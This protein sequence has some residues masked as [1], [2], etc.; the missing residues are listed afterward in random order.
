MQPINA[1]PLVS[2]VIPAFNGVNFLREAVESVFAQTYPNIELILVDDGST[3]DTWTVIQ[4]YGKRVRAIHKENGGVASALNVGILQARGSLI[5]WLS[6]DDLFFP[7]K[8]DRQVHFLEKHPQY[9]VC[10]TDFEI[11]NATGELLK[12]YRAPWYPS[13]E[14]PRHFLADMH[15]NGSTVLMRK[16]CYESAGGFNECL[17]H[18]QDLDMWLR[19]AEK[20]ELGHLPE[21]LVKFRSHPEQ[22]SLNYE[23]QIEDEQ[24][25]FR[26]LFD[27][28]GPERFFPQL[29]R[30]TDPMEKIARG[31]CLLADELRRHRKWYRFALEQYRIGNSLRP[32]LQTR[33][34]IL[35]TQSAIIL[36]GDERESLTLGKRARIYLGQ[37][38]RQQARRFSMGL[39]RRHP[40][41]VDM[42]LI[43]VVSWI[44]P[45]GMQ[46]L[47]QLKRRLS[48]GAL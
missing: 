1:G 10:Y 24:N 12:T 21:V 20:G 38:Q 8:I 27:N 40:L 35:K 19:I 9:G 37:G 44:P 42:L 14:L 11:I 39:F 41:R 15:I 23:V 26:A 43:W 36:L 5:A 30:V 16:S 6:H 17:P 48:H 32:T 47:K 28:L 29:E 3:D 45:Q 18:T 4:S 34:K 33:Q 22:G 25:L 46:F 7:E 31:R 2:V 13:K